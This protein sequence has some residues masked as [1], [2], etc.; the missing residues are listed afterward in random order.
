VGLVAAA[1]RR[2]WI[3]VELD[4]KMAALAARRLR[5]RRAPSSLVPAHLGADGEQKS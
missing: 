5:L 1:L 3:G 4:P 2:D